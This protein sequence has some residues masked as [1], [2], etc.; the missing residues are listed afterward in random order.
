[1]QTEKIDLFASESDSSPADLQIEA[2]NGQAAPSGTIGT[3]G[4]FGS[5]SSSTKG[6]VG[7]AGCISG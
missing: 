1:M 7:T 3:V 5:F 6:S 2:L 4:S